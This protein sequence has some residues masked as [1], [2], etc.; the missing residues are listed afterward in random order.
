MTG[1]AALFIATAYP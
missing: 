1:H